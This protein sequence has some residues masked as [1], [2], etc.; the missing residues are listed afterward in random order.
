MIHCLAINGIY[1]SEAGVELPGLV[2][3]QCCQVWSILSVARY[4]LYSVL[5]GLYSVL[6]GMVYTQYY[7]VW[8]ILS[9]ARYGLYSV[10]RGMVYTQY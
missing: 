9:D 8:S 1:S 10:L 7:Q 6:S 2:Y 3:T 5:P 4:G